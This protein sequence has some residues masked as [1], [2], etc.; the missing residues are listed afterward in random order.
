MADQT[1]SW[2]LELV[3]QITKPIKSIVK[4]VGK[5][6]D[7]VDEMSDTV[8]LNEKDTR[9]ALTKSKKY[10]KE[11]EGQIR[12]VEKE[13]K[14]LEKVKKNGDWAEAMEASKAFD[15][16][17]ERIDRLRKAL[18]GAEEDVD[19]LSDAVKK[20][21]EAAQKW[22]E[23]ATGINQG[24]ELIQKAT[25]GL[26]FTVDIANLTTQVER[27]TELT[28]D[29]LDEFV[30]RS[31]NIAGIYDQDAEEIARATNAMTKQNGLSYE[32]NFKLIEEGFKRG[33][34]SNG[35]FLDQ[36]LEYQPFIKQL[37]LTQSQAI[38]MIAK[39]GKDGIYDDKAIDALK[40]ANMALREMGKTQ[41]DAL[42]GIGM[43]PED[44]IGKTPFEAI[45]MISRQMK[46]ATSQ[47]RQLV[48]TDI[49]KGA[50]EDAGLKWADE[51]GN[52]DFDLTKLK[53]VEEAGA[54]MKGFFADLSTWAGQAFGNI[55]I[56][57]TEMSPMI[58]TVSA[59]IPIVEMLSKVTWIQT[60]ATKA[61]SVAQTI[62]NAIMNANPIAIVILA[63]VALIAAIAWVASSTTGWGE[64]WD[65]TMN[66][67]KY[68]F[69]AWVSMV[70]ANFNL[71]INGLMIGINKIKEGWYSFKDAVGLG[72]SSE[73]QKMLEQ[74][75]AD[76]E[77]RKESIKQGYAEATDYG[78]KAAAE[79]AKAVNSV[80]WKEEEKEES[81]TPSVNEYA[82][83]SPDVLGAIAPDDK[84]KKGKQGDGL[85]VGSGSGG[86]KSITMTLNITNNFSVSK[87]TN[88]RN[89]A[90]QITGHINDRL[91]DSVINLGG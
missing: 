84:K 80:K 60:I 53:S 45:Q 51:L 78:I 21:D 25:D 72:D 85:N 6:T 43:K 54:G 29:A 46:G 57:A 66:A 8:K 44:L 64:A 65:H 55:G 75:R 82:T 79:M 2:I 34:N 27:M 33:A 58:Q 63:I 88:I 30:R 69:L 50:G 86:I 1:T 77:E 3:D 12:D 10:Y 14:D 16:A 91:R 81:A 42:A 9:E 48:L 62:F 61:A 17:K 74:I 11:L 41:V 56:Y 20:F 89:I 28:G 32:E 47:A 18:K 23:L 13:L 71:M 5:L 4:S 76:T 19:E 52:A 39:S 38:A 22:T 31:R 40:E 90:D 73:N 37:G 68:I 87:S 24:V 36:L 7:S 83:G 35:D 70:K 67:A 26:E 49:F 15:K 59:M